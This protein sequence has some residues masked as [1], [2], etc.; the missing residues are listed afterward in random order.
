MNGHEKCKFCRLK[1]LKYFCKIAC[2]DELVFKIAGVNPH[3]KELRDIVDWFYLSLWL[4]SIG[5]QILLLICFFIYP[6][7]TICLFSHAISIPKLLSQSDGAYLTAVGGYGIFN[8]FQRF[9][10]YERRLQDTDMIM[11]KRKR[12]NGHRFIIYWWLNFLTMFLATIFF[13]YSGDLTIQETTVKETSFWIATGCS[14]IAIGYYQSRHI[15]KT[16]AQK[17]KT[18]KNSVS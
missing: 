17:L 6:D 12:R 11:E 5:Y 2:F 18:P 14:V 13:D 9:H 15:S 16:V 4:T 3:H 10:L 8:V 1:L 7:W